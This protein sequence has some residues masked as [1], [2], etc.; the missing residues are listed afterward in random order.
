MFCPLLGGFIVLS[1]RKF[2]G[3]DLIK[4]VLTGFEISA[5]HVL[6]AFRTFAYTM[7]KLGESL[8][9]CEWPKVDYGTTKWQINPPPPTELINE[10]TYL[11]DF[12][13]M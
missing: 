6:V 9:P 2:S 12:I 11:L 4:V 10:E 1:S 3:T 8:S 13:K 5:R 7:I